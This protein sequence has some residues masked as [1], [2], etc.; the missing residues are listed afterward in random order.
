MECYI[1]NLS[2]K[3][4]QTNMLRFVSL[5]EHQY[6]L[7]TI[8]ITF[9]LLGKKKTLPVITHT[10]QVMIYRKMGQVMLDKP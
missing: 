6:A 1:K 7:I 2:F 8:S 10:G 9:D 5:Q 4:F 3:K